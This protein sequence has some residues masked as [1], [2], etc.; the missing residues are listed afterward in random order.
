VAN[1][2][3]AVSD[4]VSV[5]DTAT[6]TVIATIPV[7]VAPSGV[8]ITPDG[9]RVYVTNQ[10]AASVSVIDRSTNTVIATVPVDFGPFGIAIT[11]DGTRAYVASRSAIDVIDTSTNTVVDTIPFPF[12]PNF[13]DFTPDG[14][15][16][17]VT[18]QAPSVAVIDPASN[19]VVVPNIPGTACPFGIVVGDISPAPKTKDDCKD[20]GFLR[21]SSPAFRNQGQ[22]VKFVNEHTK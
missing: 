22:C 13:L 15:R 1:G 16:L 4:T 21:F 8:A 18:S 5:I 17:Y 10:N 7:G 14:T 19:T 6:N 2:E 11:N 9:S 3:G 20:G 12:N